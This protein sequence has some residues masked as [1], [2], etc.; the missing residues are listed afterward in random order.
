MNSQWG[1]DSEEWISGLAPKYIPALP[2]DPA[3][4]T[5]SMP[6]YMY[7]SDGSDY[8]LL[9]HGNTLTCKLVARLSP[10]LLDPLRNCWGFGYWTDGARAW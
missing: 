7:R 9:A 4:S 6:Q 5:K 2:R 10:E 8:K 3:L 1:K